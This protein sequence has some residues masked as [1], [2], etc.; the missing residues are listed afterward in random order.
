MDKNII[1]DEE[2]SYKMEIYKCVCCYN[3]PCLKILI[4]KEL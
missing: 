2:L 3:A 4:P 1:V